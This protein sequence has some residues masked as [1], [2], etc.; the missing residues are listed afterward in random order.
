MKYWWR[1]NELTFQRL[2][3]SS[4]LFNDTF[5]RGFDV[6]TKHIRRRH[7]RHGGSKINCQYWHSQ[8]SGTRSRSYKK[9]FSSFSLLSLSECSLHIE[10]KSLI[11]KWP[12]LAAK[13]GKFLA[14]KEKEFYKIGSMSRSYKTFLLHYKEFFHFSLLS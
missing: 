9:F 13:N 10:K 6:V 11:I 5:K 8:Q 2:R 3:I 7:A 4:C 12:S 1:L 14:S